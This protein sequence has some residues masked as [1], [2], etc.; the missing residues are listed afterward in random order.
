MHLL[1]ALLQG[2]EFAGGQHRGQ[3]G[4]HLAAVGAG[5][6]L[7]LGR[8]VGV[9]QR[10]AHQE[11]VELRLGQREGAELV[12]R[13][14]RGDHEEGRGQGAGLALDRD[15]LFFHRLEQRALGLGAG[16]VD[17]VGQ[18]HLREDRPGVEHEGLLAPVVDRHARQVARHQVG[19]EL[20]ARELQAEGVRQRMGQGGLADPRHVLDQQVPARQQTGHAVAHLGLFANNHRVKLTQQSG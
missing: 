1:H 7:A 5:Q 8:A 2:G 4:E 11:A 14:L 19:R 18:Q 9:A 10:D 20:H 15:L 3:A 13:V 6:Q 17:L 16:A 12:L